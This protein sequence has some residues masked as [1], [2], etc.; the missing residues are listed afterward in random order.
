[1]NAVGIYEFLISFLFP[2]RKYDGKF[3]ACSQFHTNNALRLNCFKKYVADVETVV[4]LKFV[5]TWGTTK[6]LFF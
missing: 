3:I 5:G 1:M 4:H 2:N 6:T